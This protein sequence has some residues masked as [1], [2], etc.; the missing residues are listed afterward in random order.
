MLSRENSPD[1]G[2]HPPHAELRE[3]RRLGPLLDLECRRGPGP[4]LRPLAGLEPCCGEHG[5]ANQGF[6]DFGG[7]VQGVG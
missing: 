6:E 7:G 1:L 3:G 4:E 5:L 2:Y